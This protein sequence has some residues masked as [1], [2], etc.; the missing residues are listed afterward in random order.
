MTD[1]IG[2]IVDQNDGFTYLPLN[3]IPQTTSGG[4]ILTFSIEVTNPGTRRVNGW[5]RNLSNIRN[6]PEWEQFKKDHIPPGSV[7]VHC[8]YAHGEQRKDRQGNPGF[9]VKGPHTG[10]P[11]IVRLTINHRNRDSYRT[12]EDYLTWSDKDCEICCTTCNG[13]IEQG[14]MPCP[15]CHVNYIHWRQEGPCRDCREDANL[16]LKRER[17]EKEDRQGEINR[18]NR[19]ARN[20]KKSDKQRK[21]SHPCMKRGLLQRCLRGPGLVCDFTAKKCRDEKKGCYYLNK[22]PQWVRP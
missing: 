11:I 13:K 18:V 17:L 19:N 3:D 6:S 4:E 1:A 9:Y 14:L 12:R 16:E 10:K 2:S 5:R 22:N 15:Q 7:C 21:A 8:L 20:R